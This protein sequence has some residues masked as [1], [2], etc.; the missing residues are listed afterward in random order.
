MYA[1]RIDVLLKPP[2]IG[3]EFAFSVRKGNANAMRLRSEFL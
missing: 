1:S 2:R 3:I